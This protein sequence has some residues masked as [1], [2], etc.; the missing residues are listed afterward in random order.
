MGMDKPEYK[1]LI[2]KQVTFRYVLFAFVIV[3]CGN[4]A[5]FC[6]KGLYTLLSLL[7]FGEQ[8]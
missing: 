3:I 1:N 4:N 6:A 2:L 5:F 7:I 8:F